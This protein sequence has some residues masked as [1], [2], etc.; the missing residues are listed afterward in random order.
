M[1][2]WIHWEGGT[3]IGFLCDH[4]LS[5]H[6]LLKAD[7]YLWSRGARLLIATQKLMSEERTEKREQSE[8]RAVPT[9]KD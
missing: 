4:I 6:M 3:N 1:D 7:D 9:V 5:D 2:V 8:R